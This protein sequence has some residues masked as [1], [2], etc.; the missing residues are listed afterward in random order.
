MYLDTTMQYGPRLDSYPGT[1]RRILRL[2]RRPP[3]PESHTCPSPPSPTRTTGDTEKHERETEEEEEKLELQMQPHLLPRF[4]WF[5]CKCPG[6]WWV[7]GV[8][9][10]VRH[11]HHLVMGS[12]GLPLNTS[13]LSPP[14][15]LL[16][17]PQ[18]PKSS[19]RQECESVSLSDRTREKCA[20]TG[21]LSPEMGV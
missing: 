18:L 5:T 16:S 13:A 17:S 8:T 9:W 3:P 21:G 19:L 11:P 15:S 7:V 14:P 12:S 2:A 4:P 20:R 6:E 1:V 10:R